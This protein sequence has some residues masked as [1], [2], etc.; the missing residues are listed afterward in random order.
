MLLDFSD[1]D[2]MPEVVECCGCVDVLLCNSSMKLK[3]VHTASLEL[4]RN[5]MDI[6][7]FGPSTLAKGMKDFSQEENACCVASD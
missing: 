2:G 6:N 5:I 1:M 7:Y 4:D 3:A